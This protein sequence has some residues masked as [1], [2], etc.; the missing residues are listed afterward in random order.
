MPATTRASRRSTPE[1]TATGTAGMTTALDTSS[2]GPEGGLTPAMRPREGSRTRPPRED[3]YHPKYAVD[4]AV[5]DNVFLFPSNLIGYLRVVLAGASLCI[6]PIHPRICTVLYFTSCI[7]DVADGQVA[8]ALNQTSKFGA[9]LDMVTDRCTTA[10]LLCFLAIAYKPWALLFQ[11]LISLDFSSHYMHMYSSLATGSTSHKTVTSDVSRILWLYYNNK[12]TLFI[13][14]FA[15]ETF[16]FCLYLNK[17]WTHSIAQSLP[18]LLV[19]CRDLGLP[20]GVAAV[21]G[22]VS[23]P[24]LVAGVTFPICAGKQVIN[25]VQFWKASKILVGVDIAERQAKREQDAKARQ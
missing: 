3:V 11:F 15:N 20:A 12:I 24:Q 8:R 7:L 13:F 17:F 19:M 4:L 16:F 14:C 6:M 18:F 23:W 9:V 21:L 22:R 2:G 10:C 1:P 5:T 25:V